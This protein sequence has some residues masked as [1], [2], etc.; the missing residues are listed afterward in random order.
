MNVLITSCSRKVSL[1]QAFQRAVRPYGG[2][3]IAADCQPDA[4]ALHVADGGRIVP[5]LSDPAFLDAVAKIVRE[6]RIELLIPT[7]DAELPFFAA[8]AERLAWLG[9]TVPISS[10]KTIA[11]CQDKGAFAHFC[12]E[13]GFSVARLREGAALADASLY[14]MFARTR[15]GA[16]SKGAFSVASPAELAARIAEH[17]PLVVQERVDAPELSLDVLAD[18]SG[19]VISV[20]PRTRSVIVGG[21]SFVSRTLDDPELVQLGARLAR[22]LDLRGHAVMQV[23]DRR[24]SE[25]GRIDII[26]VNPRFGGASAL[27]IEAGCDSPAFLVAMAR[28]ER[29]TPRLGEH[30]AGLTMLRYT[31]DVFVPAAG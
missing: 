4:A 13:S 3:V 6:E 1:V 21:E 2:R 7:R 9:V 20:V 8:Q 17:G 19:E 16:S 25:P 30:I 23:F 14:P 28:G 26:E 27:A 11:L 29:V 5:R 18:V 15:T 10:S 12:L 31:Q 22:A 24:A